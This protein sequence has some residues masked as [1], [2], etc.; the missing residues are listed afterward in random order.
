MVHPDELPGYE[1]KSREELI[2]L[3]RQRDSEI[4]TWRERWKE[5]QGKRISLEAAWT[6]TTPSD[7]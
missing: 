1:A 7:S 6:P 4:D 5:E 2:R 3:V